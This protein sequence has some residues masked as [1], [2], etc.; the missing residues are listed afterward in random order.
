MAEADLIRFLKEDRERFIEEKDRM[1]R[2]NDRLVRAIEQSHRSEITLLSDQLKRSNTEILK[3]SGS[4]SVR[5]M[6][7][8]M[9]VQYSEMRRTDK[10][11]TRTAVWNEI[12]VNFPDLRRSLIESVAVGTEKTKLSSTIAAIAEIY[13]KTSE[14]IHHQGSDEIPIKTKK[15]Q[16][17][18]LPVLRALCTG[19][20]YAFK[21]Y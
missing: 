12:A 16:G 14:E 4:L 21:E 6:I 8:K 7:E 10:D 18:E 5:G 11:A 1:I 13:R 17:A 9:E 2:D 20:K 15:F 19:G 3:L